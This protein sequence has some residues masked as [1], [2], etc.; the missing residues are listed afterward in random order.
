MKFYPAGEHSDVEA[1]IKLEGVGFAFGR[2]QVLE[3]ISLEIRRGDFLAVLGP[4][5]AGKTTLL[6][7]ILG[8]YQPGTGMLKLFGMD[9][10]RFRERYRIG[11]V[12]QKGAAFGDFPATV[13]EVVATGRT[14]RAGLWRRL[15]PKDREKITAALSAL[16]L[17]ELAHRPVRALSGGQRQ[18]VAIARALAAEPEVLLLDEAA[19]GL[20]PAGEDAFYGLLER[21]NR[22][23]GMTVVLVT[24]DIGAV[25]RRV[26]KV[27]FLNRRIV[28]EGASEECLEN[29]K[30]S[31]LYGMPV[32]VPG[33]VGRRRQEVYGKGS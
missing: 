25:S 23:Q 16:G 27:V 10:S 13:W 1:V 11:Y 9:G 21:L 28:F 22:G 15:A 24:H 32:Y 7:I 31:A 17:E 6:K 12:P 8:L 14:A 2:N 4:N 33:S 29:G 20:D 26:R 19:E 5:G 3:N 30:L 18:R